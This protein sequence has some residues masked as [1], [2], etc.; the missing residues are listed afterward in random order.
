MDKRI[1]D[2]LYLLKAKIDEMVTSTQ[3]T[4]ND[5]NRF[6]QD[7]TQ[8]S[9]IVGSVHAENMMLGWRKLRREIRK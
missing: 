1:R 5:M 7:V 9:K 3:C 8:V 2:A 4:P 6:M